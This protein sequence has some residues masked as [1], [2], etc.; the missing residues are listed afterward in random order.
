M[1]STGVVVVPSSALG[2][3]DRVKLY[4]QKWVCFKVVLPLIAASGC[5]TVRRAWM[6]WAKKDQRHD[7]TIP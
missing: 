4:A 6:G 7:V 2:V 5:L 1:P 3:L